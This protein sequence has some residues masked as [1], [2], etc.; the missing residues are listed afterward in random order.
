MRKPPKLQPGDMVGIVSPSWGGAG[1]FPHRTQQGLAQLEALG[2]RTRL[3]KH[4]LHHEGYVSSSPA[5]RA[6][7]IH[8]LFADPQVRA[9]I[10]SIGGNHSCHLLPLLDFDLIARNPKIFMGYS[11]ITV[12]NVAIWQRAG[13]VTFN[14]P[15]LITDFAE[16]PRMLAYTQEYF[17]KT[18][19]ASSAVG[20]VEPSAEWTEEFLDWGHQKDRE[21]PRQMQPSPGWTWLK[22]G[23]AE[24]RLVGGCLESLEHLRGT[25]FWPD[26]QGAI[27]FWETSE[28]KP[29]PEDVDAML[30][31][32][33]NMGVFDRLA[34]MIVGR[35]M[36]YTDAEKQRLREVILERTAGFSFPVIT[37]MDFGHTA[38]QITLPV[39]CRARIDADCRQFAIIEPA[40]A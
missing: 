8:E 15:A 10:A 37:D 2:Y 13:L 9:V 27:F 40:V 14:G 11:D 1:A 39:G 5:Q 6:A 19:A 35:P 36:S 30:M 3:A 31:D 20:V 28:E 21:R 38:P 7:D 17:L 23:V 29:T 4:A 24:G 25:Q 16:Y 32:Y 22:P 12:L 33:H 18:V 34:G 26:W